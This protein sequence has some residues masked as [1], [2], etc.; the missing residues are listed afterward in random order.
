MNPTLKKMVEDLE[1]AGEN[2]GYMCGSNVVWIRRPGEPYTDTPTLYSE[3][4]VGAALEAGLLIETKVLGG[5]GG[6]TY[7]ILV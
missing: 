3:E 4:D 1:A 5:G 2:C 7:Y 6:W